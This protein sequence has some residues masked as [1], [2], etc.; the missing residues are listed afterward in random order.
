MG[1][2]ISKKRLPIPPANGPAARKK[3]FDGLEAM[4]VGDSVLVEDVKVAKNLYHQWKT[5]MRRTDG[6][7]YRVWRVE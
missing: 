3:P 2:K 7:K 4:E 1:Y 5:T 6:G